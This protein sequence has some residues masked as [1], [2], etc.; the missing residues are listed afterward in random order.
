MFVA[1]SHAPSQGGRDPSDPQIFGISYMSAHTYEK[2]KPNSA[3]I[4]LDVR[5]I[6]TRSTM[7][8]T[9]DLFAV[10]NFLV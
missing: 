5:K 6:C 10:A 9:R 7:K 1:V 4:K 8:L 3:V 2:Q